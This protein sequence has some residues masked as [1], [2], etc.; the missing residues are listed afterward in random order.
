M[1]KLKPP[2]LVT[3]A[4]LTTITIVFWVFYSLYGILTSDS[5]QKVPSEI[6]APIDPTL[7]TRALDK[8]PGRI[9][10]EEGEVKVFTAPLESESPESSET[11]VP[12]PT[13]TL[14]ASELTATAS[15]T[16]VST[17]SASVE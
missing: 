1:K 8:L 7:D 17:P 5:L 12:T 4:I 6:L 3:V 14:E 15:P 9:F 13:E 2:R 16:V 10:F 11:Q